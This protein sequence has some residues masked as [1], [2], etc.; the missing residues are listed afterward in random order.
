MAAA[1]ASNPEVG[2]SMKTIEGLATSSTAIVNRFR[3]SVDRP[4]IPG[5]PTSAPLNGV[6]STSSIISSTK[7]WQSKRLSYLFICIKTIPEGVY[8]VE[9]GHTMF[10]TFCVFKS[11]SEDN[12]SQ[13]E[14]SK[15]SQTVKQGE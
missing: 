4:S 15:D 8:N 14:N 13:A 6:S 1:R 12:R 9:K 10:H 2:S 5:R 3:C 7:A 11:T